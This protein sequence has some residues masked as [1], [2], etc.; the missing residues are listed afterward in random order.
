SYEGRGLGWVKVLSNRVNNYYQRPGESGWS[1]PMRRL[2]IGQNS[3]IL[4]VLS[5]FPLKRLFFLCLL[6]TATASAFAG[7]R[8]SLIIHTGP[9]GWHLLHEV[10]PGESILSISRRYHV[11]YEILASTNRLQDGED[12]SR[13]S[14]LR[15]PLDDYNIL[16][17]PPR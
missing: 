9:Q 5:L 1:C 10:L 7:T 14:S 6:F 3:G 4:Q 12:L 15:V 17:R 2:K 8:D 13:I 11:P 16:R